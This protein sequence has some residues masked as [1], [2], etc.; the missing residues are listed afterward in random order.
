MRFG[1]TIILA[2]LE[3]EMTRLTDS[4]IK[5]TFSSLF[6]YFYDNSEIHIFVKLILYNVVVQYKV[7]YFKVCVDCRRK[8]P[9][10][11]HSTD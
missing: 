2:R 9:A 1:V 10:S 4:S 11:E 7:Y 3:S 5:M 6:G 8:L